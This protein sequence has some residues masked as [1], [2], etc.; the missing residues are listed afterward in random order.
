MIDHLGIDWGEEDPQ[1][2]W[3]HTLWPHGSRPYYGHHLHKAE[4]DSGIPPELSA[5]WDRTMER[6]MP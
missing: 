5:A 2:Y 1:P 4:Q 3:P 6:F